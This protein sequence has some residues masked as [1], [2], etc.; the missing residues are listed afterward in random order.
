MK[1][2]LVVSL[3]L[4][5]LSLAVTGNALQGNAATDQREAVSIL[6]FNEILGKSPQWAEE[7]IGKFSSQAE[8]KEWLGRKDPP[9]NQAVGTGFQ[10]FLSDSKGKLGTKSLE[11]TITR[12]AGK[13]PLITSVKWG[14]APPQNFDEV[15]SSAKL[16]LKDF[17][18]V[19]EKTIMYGWDV[20]TL[21]R[22]DN[23][24]TLLEINRTESNYSLTLRLDLHALIRESLQKPSPL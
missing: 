4:G 16:E 22:K 23:P 8:L 18:F 3:Y 19:S 1:A 24:K 6:S 10:I 20:T 13:S 5:S 17:E 21:R 15:F 7:N 2:S 9:I 11:V 12:I 14:M